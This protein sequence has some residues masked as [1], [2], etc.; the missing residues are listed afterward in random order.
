LV[1]GD[2]VGAL[3]GQTDGVGPPLAACGTG[4]ERYFSLNS[5]HQGTSPSVMSAVDSPARP[6]RTA[7]RSAR[8]LRA[9]VVFLVHAS[10]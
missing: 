9:L 7:P 2:D 4:D 8:P 1:D 3:L 6:V 10:L 5:A